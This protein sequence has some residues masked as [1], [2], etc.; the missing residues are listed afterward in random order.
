MKSFIL[1]ESS[2]MREVLTASEASSATRPPY[3]MSAVRAS[4]RWLRRSAAPAYCRNASGSTG[5][6]VVACCR[7]RS[8]AS[9]SPSCRSAR[10]Y[11]VSVSLVAA[12]FPAIRASASRAFEPDLAER[13]IDERFVRSLFERGA[14]REDRELPAAGARV[15]AADCHLTIDAAAVQGSQPL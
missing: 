3:W 1:S 12:G 2:A 10:P 8:A 9:T 13:A 14:E 7:A 11:S 6:R 5:K 4:D 15:L